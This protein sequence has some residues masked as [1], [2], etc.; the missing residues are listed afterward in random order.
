MEQF[1]EVLGADRVQLA[2]ALTQ[3]AG[4]RRRALRDISAT[5]DS[6]VERV[7][8][9]V[10]DRE[11]HPFLLILQP[12]LADYATAVSDALTV[13]TSGA[14]TVVN[15]ANVLVSSLIRSVGQKLVWIAG[16][17][18]VLDLNCARVEGRLAGDTSAGRFESYVEQ[19]RKPENLRIFL[20]EYPVLARKL[21]AV[22]RN[23]AERTVEMLNRLHDDWSEIQQTFAVARDAKVLQIRT[24]L[25]DSHRHG[26]TVTSMELSDGRLLVYKPRRLD[27]D[28]A[29][30][31]VVSF[32]NSRIHR[33][34]LKVPAVLPKG[35]YGWAE[36]I[37][38][39]ACRDSNELR[40]FYVAQ[41]GLLALLYALEATDFHSENLVAC[42]K[43]PVPLDL[44]ALFHPRLPFDD[45]ASEE[46]KVI[47]PGYD[48]M[49][50]SV[51]RVGFLPQRI[52]ATD[53]SKGI[54][55]SGFGGAAGQLSP[56]KVPV[57]EDEG[58]D[59]MRIVHKQLAMSG[60][61]NRPTIDGETVDVGDYNEEVSSGFAEVYRLIMS[62]RNFLLEE[63]GLLDKFSP[64]EVR[65]VLR[66]TRIYGLMLNASLHPDALQE[67]VNHERAF[68]LL[69]KRCVE[70][71]SRYR[72]VILSE[73]QDLWENDIP[74]FTSTIGGTSLFDCRG[75]EFPHF[76]TQSALQRV[77]ERVLGLSE[78][79]LQRQLSYINGSLAC[80]RIGHHLESR[81]QIEPADA[82]ITLVERI[83]RLTDKLDKRL[84]ETS[85]SIGPNS[86]WLGLQLVDESY[87]VFRPL[88]LD[89]YSGLPGV[90]LYLA[91]SDHLNPRHQVRDLAER[92][93]EMVVS[94]VD[95]LLDNPS[96]LSVGGVFSGVGGVIY[97]LSQVCGI[98]HNAD[99]YTKMSYFIRRLQ[100]RVGQ[101]EHSDIIG[102]TAGWLLCL[103]AA[104][105]CSGS[106]NHFL[107]EIEA[108]TDQL[109]NAKEG[110]DVEPTWRGGAEAYAPLT[111][112]SHGAAGI[113]YALLKASLALGRE[114]LLELA[115][116]SLS[117]ESKLMSESEENWPD[118]RTDIDG[119]IPATPNYQND[120]CHGAPGIGLS[121]LAFLQSSKAHS[122]L[123]RELRHAM[124]STIRRG[125]GR[126]HSLCHGD[127]GNL[128]LLLG[129]SNY[130]NSEL[131]NFV[132]RS[133]LTEV[134]ASVERSGFLCG[135]PEHIESPGLMTGLAGIGY[136]L[137]RMLRPAEVPSVL[138][139][140]PPTKQCF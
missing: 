61:A 13:G 26:A 113:A 112:F 118:F 59:T 76:L 105:T 57:F 139:L 66:A 56:H 104:A 47:D 111:G 1:L 55:L 81:P 35:A 60:G 122:E 128:E 79:D 50:N 94:H 131:A 91:Y 41:G 22:V 58:L 101:F 15:D 49:E 132:Y 37:R 44:E 129:Y 9:L 34:Q 69:W 48:V 80:L 137:L 125:F 7:E 123:E 54:D 85:V 36:G 62:E 108:T 83:T 70:K 120:W 130:E 97:L 38:H 67:G 74:I 87:W 25:G 65:V 45:D 43:Y 19:M 126:N 121:R 86:N 89:L 90:A 100:P 75:K 14:S 24:D 21:R 116:R 28:R 114:D 103:I 107:E 84:I 46:E 42:G 5:P 53:A 63:N 133:K 93:V 64:H 51:F 99:L 11:V 17:A 12:L 23:S 52:W 31:E 39:S 73:I 98:W 110:S 117:Y 119:T 33:F 88:G 136:G 68:H 127:L 78:S 140:E 72:R 109:V 29:F 115:V 77:R 71:K 40:S 10:V 96:E 102:G 135:T 82:E 20:S 134:V 18:L 27:I 8:T 124:N 92:V 30:T 4:L 138:L 95:R 3:A 2:H 106:T 6:G 16:K 32:V